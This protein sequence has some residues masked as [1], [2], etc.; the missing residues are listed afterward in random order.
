MN[1]ISGYAQTETEPR[2][3]DILLCSLISQ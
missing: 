1:W 2:K 3:K